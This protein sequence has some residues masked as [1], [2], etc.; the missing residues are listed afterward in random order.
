MMTGS[1]AVRP[2]GVF[3]RLSR[4]LGQERVFRWIPFVLVEG[5]FVLV[6]II[7]FLLTV[8]ISL[9]RWRANRTSCSS[10]WMTCAWNLD[11]TETA[12]SNRRTSMRWPRK[13]RCSRAPIV[14]KR[15]AIRREHRC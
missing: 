6:I 10:P 14:N 9:L 1:E 8:Y 15:C 12:R 13:A 11:A 4:W 5:T 2:R 3:A 7:P